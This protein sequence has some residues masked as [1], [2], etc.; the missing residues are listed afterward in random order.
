MEVTKKARI[1]LVCVSNFSRRVRAG[2]RARLSVQHRT[3]L[4]AFPA[5]K[6]TVT[7]THK[8]AFEH[9]RVVNEHSVRNLQ[10]LTANKHDC[11]YCY[12]LIGSRFNAEG[13][14]EA[15]FIKSVKHTFQRPLRQ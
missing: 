4:R 13:T 10:T 7:I 6:G 5:R 2:A 8:M 11:D 14:A 9:N 15:H 1:Y 3:T 12:Y